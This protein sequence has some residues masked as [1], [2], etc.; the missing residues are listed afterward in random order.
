M[1]LNPTACPPDTTGQRGAGMGSGGRL[2]QAT[3]CMRLSLCRTADNADL[4]TASGHRDIVESDSVLI[5][6]FMLMCL[7]DQIHLQPAHIS[8]HLSAVPITA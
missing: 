1:K 3:G 8:P 7:F 2:P 6:S 4:A 5:L